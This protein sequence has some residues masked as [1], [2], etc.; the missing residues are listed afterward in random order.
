MKPK[1]RWQSTKRQNKLL[2]PLYKIQQKYAEE[3]VSFMET[4]SP[5]IHRIAYYWAC[6][7][8]CALAFRL[9]END[10]AKRKEK[11]NATPLS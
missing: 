1:L 9:T 7:V 2:Q 3:V 6:D 10:I 4:L 8:G 11:R 5:D